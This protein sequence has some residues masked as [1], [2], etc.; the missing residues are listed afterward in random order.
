MRLFFFLK[1]RSHR[2]RRSSGMNTWPMTFRSV[3]TSSSATRT[4]W[5]SS[6]ERTAP[7]ESSSTQVSNIAIT[8]NIGR[9]GGWMVRRWHGD[10]ACAHGFYFRYS[11][12]VDLA[13]YSQ[14][15]DC[16]LNSRTDGCLAWLPYCHTVNPFHS[17]WQ[18]VLPFLVC[19]LTLEEKGLNYTAVK[20][21]TIIVLPPPA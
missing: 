11:H 19:F 1:R 6:S 10:H 5:A 21:A 18:K 14:W 17:F 20:L 12:K 2:R 9:A 13:F 7:T 4:G 8:L 3:V 16:Q 15:V